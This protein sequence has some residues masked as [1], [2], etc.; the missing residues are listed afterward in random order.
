M[1]YDVRGV[2]AGTAL[3]E[4]IAVEFG[5]GTRAVGLEQ[6]FALVPY[7]G[8]AYDHFLGRHGEPLHP[9]GSLRATVAALLADASRGGPVAYVEADYFGGTGQQHAAVWDGGV[10]AW[11]PMTIVFRQKTPPQGT[12][13]SQALRRLGVISPDESQDEF[14]AVGLRRHRHLEDWLPEMEIY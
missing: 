2:I 6:G 8:T 4:V 12:A 13:I 3:A 1:G 7:T 5:P 14:D 10:L 9:F 11:G